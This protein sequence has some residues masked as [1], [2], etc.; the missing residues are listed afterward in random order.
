[1]HYNAK[2]IILRMHA[3]RTL[4]G[5]MKRTLLVSAVAAGVGLGHGSA[6]AQFNQFYFFGD[7]LTDAGVYGARFTV[8][9]GL[10]WA[11]D[12]GNRYGLSVT[13][14]TQGG[15]DYA[16]GGA[17][18]SLPSPLIPAGAPQRS[19][20][21]QID[22]LLRA[23][24]KLNPAAVYSVWIGAD[25]IIVNVQA[26]GSGQL[27]PALV[28]P[29]I[30]AAAKDTLAQIARLRDAGAKRVM[31]FNL[32]DIGKTPLGLSSPTAPFSALSGLFNSTLEA[33][34]TSLK[35]DI[36]P[37]NVFGLFNEVIA[38]PAAYGLINVTSPACT[39]ASS[40]N[41]T[42]ATLVAPNAA[43]TYVFADSLHP[44]PAGHQIISDYTA[45]IIEAPQKI[46][47]MAEA[48]LQVEQAN[49][50]ALDDRMWSNLNMARPQ[51]KFD[52]YAVYDYGN[53][54]H[55]DTTGGSENKLNTIVAGIDMKISEQMLAGIAFGY[56]ENKA[57][58]GNNAGGFNLDEATIT[59]YVGYGSGPWYVGATLGGGDLD[60]RDIRRTFALGAG[61]RTENGDARGTHLMARVF[62]GYWF[63][64][65][66][67]WIHGPWGRYTYQQARVDAWAESGTSSSAMTFDSQTRNSS[68]VSLGWQASGTIGT[69]HPFGRVTWE[70]DFDN[71]DRSVR[72]GLVSMPGTFAIPVFQTDNSYAL[73]NIGVSADLGSKLVG[74]IGVSAT[75]GKD[76]GNYQAVTVGLRMPM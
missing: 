13:P 43:Q 59:G 4:M 62:G 19:M 37:V 33:G 42:S 23:T 10:V 46:G 14:S 68:A 26:A 6:S 12:L 64:T 41:C 25:D 44:T 1:M 32:P 5:S 21:V 70:R 69:L 40:L 47:L 48:P 49:F 15:V 39:V 35:V 50:R 53:F 34:L 71:D 31:V 36:I 52:A 18:V 75:A 63:N 76:D 54:D 2:K 29:N 56:T 65:T 11:Q 73:F 27:D 24:P 3:R 9:P 57:S 60:Y 74:F 66:G 38:N 67:G 58:F 61:S 28:Q 51:N 20:S 22:E 8:N 17:R 72:A 55:S 16:Q 30:V 7:S 45:A